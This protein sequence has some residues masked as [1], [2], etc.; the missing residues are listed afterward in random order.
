LSGLWNN[1]TRRTWA[2][3]S[4]IHD[5][6]AAQVRSSGRIADRRESA[7]LGGNTPRQYDLPFTEWGL[8]EWKEYDPVKNGD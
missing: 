5:A 1:R 2:A 8:K 7:R 6:R 3:A 4:S